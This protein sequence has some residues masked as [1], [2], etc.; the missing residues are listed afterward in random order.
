MPYNNFEWE[1]FIES[2]NVLANQVLF[3]INLQYHATTSRGL[4]D[5]WLY[6]WLCQ[7]ANY[8]DFFGQNPFW[9]YATLLYFLERILIIGHAIHFFLLP[10]I[11]PSIFFFCLLATFSS[12]SQG[13]QSNT[14]FALETSASDVWISASMVSSSLI[15]SPSLVRKITWAPPVKMTHSQHEGGAPLFSCSANFHQIFCHC[16]FI[17]SWKPL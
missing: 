14:S 8:C 12:P 2:L 3:V 16:S 10:F 5:G 11:Y 6:C 17:G 9:F 4:Q 15:V 1:I 13:G 7:N